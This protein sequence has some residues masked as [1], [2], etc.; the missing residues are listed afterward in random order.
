MFKCIGAVRDGKSQEMLRIA[1]D[2][3]ENGDSVL[4]KLVPEP[5]N[6]KDAKAVAFMSEIDGT[7]TRIGYVV[8]EVL[9]HVHEAMNAKQIVSVEF[10]WIKYITQWGESGPGYFAGISVSKEGPWDPQVTKYR[11]KLRV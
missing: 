9:E 11:S 2:K 4:V 5:T 1:R 3:I 8:K 10:A 7:W 6:P